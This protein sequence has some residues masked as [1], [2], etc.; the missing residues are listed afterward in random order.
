MATI[1]QSKSG[2]KVFNRIY[3]LRFGNPALEVATKYEIDDERFT[4]TSCMKNLYKEKDDYLLVG[5]NKTVIILQVREFAMTKLATI[6]NI[7]SS[8]VLDLGSLAG[9]VL[10]C[11]GDDQFFQMIYISEEWSKHQNSK[12]LLPNLGFK[13]TLPEYDGVESKRMKL[14]GSNYS[15]IEVTANSNYL[16]LSGE[17]PG[18]L[19][20][21]TADETNQVFLESIY[22][23]IQKRAYRICTFTKQQ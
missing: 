14:P 6:S 23:V 8:P 3:M 21:N 7:H 10:T 4:S 1:S 13:A 20:I 12:Y 17:S 19:R 11:C 15:R 5:G 18:I 2:K 22:F 9:S 16:L